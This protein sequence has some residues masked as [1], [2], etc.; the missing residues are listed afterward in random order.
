MVF[1]WFSYFL[2]V[3]TVPGLV[4]VWLLYLTIVGRN[5]N[6]FRK[7]VWVYE[8][9]VNDNKAEYHEH[10][11]STRIPAFIS[12]K[13]F[14]LAEKRCIYTRLG[15]SPSQVWDKEFQAVL[16]SNFNVD[17]YSEAT[18]KQRDATAEILKTSYFAT[19]KQTTTDKIAKEQLARLK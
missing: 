2:G 11:Y 13:L 3:L 4:L 8:H 10:E 18:D 7:S 1:D 17:N 6:T 9:A 12:R 5:V 19:P 14:S 15:L 16:K